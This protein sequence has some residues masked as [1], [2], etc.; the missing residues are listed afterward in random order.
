MSYCGETKCSRIRKNRKELKWQAGHLEHILAGIDALI[1]YGGWPLAANR[2]WCQKLL[3]RSRLGLQR[4]TLYHSGSR[5]FSNRIVNLIDASLRST[6]HCEARF[7][8]EFEAL[9]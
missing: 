6:V 5:S 1:H 4:R 7:N 3:V 2:H 9:V 8:V